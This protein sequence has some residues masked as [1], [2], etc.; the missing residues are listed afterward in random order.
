MP[1]TQKGSRELIAYWSQHQ[2]SDNLG[3]DWDDKDYFKICWRC[4][5]KFK[6]LTPCHI[7]P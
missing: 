6:T 2:N 7:I 4:A 1:M 3:F 5:Y